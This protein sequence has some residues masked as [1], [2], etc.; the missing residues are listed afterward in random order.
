MVF[1]LNLYHAVM[2]FQKLQRVFKKM[3][4]TVFQSF[5]SGFEETT[6]NDEVLQTK[7]RTERV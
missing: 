7:K 3:K 1:C 6:K 2:L 4:T 5:T